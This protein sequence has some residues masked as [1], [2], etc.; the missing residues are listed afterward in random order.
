MEVRLDGSY[1]SFPTWDILFCCMKVPILTLI[2]PPQPFHILCLISNYS[3]DHFKSLRRAKFQQFFNIRGKNPIYLSCFVRSQQVLW[4]KGCPRTWKELKA[5]RCIR[6]SRGQKQFYFEWV[7]STQ[8]LLFAPVQCMHFTTFPWHVSKSCRSHAWLSFSVAQY[9]FWKVQKQQV[10][11]GTSV[12]ACDLSALPSRWVHTA[13]VS[14]TVHGRNST[15]AVAL[16]AFSSIPGEDLATALI[17]LW[18]C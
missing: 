15:K 14:C 16:M 2:S 10:R 6:S 11:A 12:P 17:R 1:R 18:H 4:L 3:K 5:R 13:L 9:Y 8:R 7:Q